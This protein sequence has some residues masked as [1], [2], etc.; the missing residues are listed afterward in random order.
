MDAIKSGKVHMRPRAYFTLLGLVSAGAV[1]LAGVSTTYLASII[2]FWV[3]IETADTMAYGARAN[4]SE[5]VASFP[6]WALIAA[7][8][9][10][11]VA[12]VLVRHFGKM[13]K[14]KTTTVAAVLII[15]SLLIGLGLS[16][17]DIGK[18][19]AP[20]QLEG[21]GQNQGTWRNR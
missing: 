15:G 9:L 14:H 18:S 8:V 2:F 20:S 3:R 12:I 16:F 1:I 19:H 10:M 17:L 7:A 5:L 21:R 4:L 6:W 13:Y 11:A